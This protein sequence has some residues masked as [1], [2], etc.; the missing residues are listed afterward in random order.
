MNLE[1]SR[2]GVTAYISNLFGLISRAIILLA[3]ASCAPIIAFKPIPPSPTTATVLPGFTWAVLMIAP[4][5]VITAHPKIAT[6]SLDS[7][8]F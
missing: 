4:I 8:P 5:P 6:F 1:I 2:V 7:A 3:P